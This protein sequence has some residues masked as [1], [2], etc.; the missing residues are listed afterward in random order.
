LAGGAAASVYR[1]RAALP[2]GALVPRRAD[3]AALPGLADRALRWA[4]HS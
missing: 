3:F 2:L 4:V 1:R